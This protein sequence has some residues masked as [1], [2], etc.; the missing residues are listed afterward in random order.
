MFAQRTRAS[1]PGVLRAPRGPMPGQGRARPDLA[2]RPFA[3]KSA[4]TALLSCPASMAALYDLMLLIDSSAPEDRQREIVGEVDSMLRSGGE[5]VGA[6]DWGSR[7]IAFEIDHRPEA[8]YHLFQFQGGN[9]LLDR[10][11]YSLRVMDGVLRFRVIRQPPGTP[12]PPARAEPPP[13]ERDD[14]PDGRVAARAAADAAPEA[15]ETA[16]PDALS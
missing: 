15:D 11:G 8:A 13:A 6:H 4:G 1:V 10:L 16:P 7:K 9:D 14:Q 2:P 5:V 3:P 12:P